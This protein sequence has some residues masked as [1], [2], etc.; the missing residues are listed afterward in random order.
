MGFAVIEK[1]PVV[2][3]GPLLR[4]DCSIW[5]MVLRPQRSLKM[6]LLPI[7]ISSRKKKMSAAAYLGIFFKETLDHLNHSPNLL[8]I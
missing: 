7:A 4:S 8:N 3:I 1:Y 5:G 2:R 6:L